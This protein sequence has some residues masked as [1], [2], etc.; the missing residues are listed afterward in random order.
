MYTVVSNFSGPWEE[1]SVLVEAGRHDSVS[2][3]ERLFNT[4]TVVHV[5]VDV[6]HPLMIS[7]ISVI[8]ITR[9]EH[10]EAAPGYPKRYLD[11]ALKQTEALSGFAP[12]T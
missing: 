2:R 3:I 5:D 10:T 12:F 4:V 7:T 8:H 9:G 11:S 6:K 1:F